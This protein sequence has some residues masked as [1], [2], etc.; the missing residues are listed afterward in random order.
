MN[1]TGDERR[2]R[3]RRGAIGVLRH[4]PRY[5][6][7]QRASGIPKGGFWCF[8]GGHIEPGE[9]SRDAVK[10]ELS[11]EL[12]IEVETVERVGAVRVLDTNHVLAVWIVKRIGGVFRPAPA[13][14]ADVR[15]LTA[16]EILT[17]PQTIPSNERVLKMLGE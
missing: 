1:A 8:P 16:D 6:M 14:I 5:C 17:I 11:E 2:V 3:V 15:W 4:G 13:E 7:V 12:G 9:T 10:R